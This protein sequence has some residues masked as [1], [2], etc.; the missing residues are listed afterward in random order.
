MDDRD[1]LTD[2]AVPAIATTSLKLIKQFDRLCYVTAIAHPIA[3]QR[4]CS[5]A[6][7]ADQI[8]VAWSD[9][10]HQ[11]EFWLALPLPAAAL[12]HLNIVALPTGLIQIELTDAAIA[13]WLN[14]PP[15]TALP[16]PATSLPAA[17]L[18]LFPAQHAHARCC[19]LL[20]LAHEH[21]FIRL[22]A[23]LAQPNQWRLITPDPIPWLAPD[24]QLQI[25][26]TA[27]RVLIQALFSAL[28]RVWRSPI[29]TRSSIFS[30][31]TEITQ[32]FYAFHSA[33]PWFGKPTPAPQR[34]QAQLGLLLVTQRLLGWLLEGWLQELAPIEL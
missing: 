16:L 5:V 3:A 28:D 32:A 17:S 19:S 24:G 1:V 31:I 14:F 11:P 9:R 29:Q 4:Q 12:P 8:A 2:T 10:R 26:H 21:Q 30:L 22:D 13:H 20:R 23:P 33:H 34:L 6:L 25:N 15:Q 27:D 18:A 7:V